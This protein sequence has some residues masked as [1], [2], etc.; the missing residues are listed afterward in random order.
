M[1]A[2]SVTGNLK[3]TAIGGGTDS[4][5]AKY[6]S[7][8]NQTW[9]RQVAP[10]SNDQANAVI[11]DASGNIYVGGQVN[12][13]IAVGQSSAGGTDA[14]VTK[15]TAQGALVY[16]RQLG[17]TADDATRQ[18]AIAADGNLVVA[19]VQN[20][21][22][23]LTKYGSADGTSAAL[24]QLDLGDLQGGG[25]SGLAIANGEIYLSGT[26]SNASLDASGAASVANPNSG[27]RD[28]FVFA[29]ADAGASVTADFVSYVGTG[30]SEQ[31]GGV[32]VAG[33]KLYLTGTTIGTF[34]GETPNTS[35]AHNLFVAE[36]NSDGTVNWTKQYGG[37][38][39]ESSGAAIVADESGASVLDALK[40]PRGTLRNNA[41]NQ[42]ESQTTVRAGDYF[43][44]K[45]AG[46]TGTREAKI[47][48]AEGE[49]LR[50]LAVKINGAL[51]FDG[52]ATALP[53]KGGQGLK[54]S[55]N[56]GVQVELVPG[57]KGFRCAR[58]I[59]FEAANADQ[60]SGPE[61]LRRQGH[62]EH[63]CERVNASDHRT[64]HRCEARSL[65]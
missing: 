29:A 56:A 2:G 25:L 5:V 6:D 19:S 51:L 55:V 7:D 34:P 53:I 31:G 42:I 63:R 43:T 12:G 18:V 45:I 14:Y 65:G 26:T 62:Q 40:L 49:T 61:E 46:K 17:T 47:T 64:W 10:A 13:P 11:I 58:G 37:L 33:G 39:G 21:H 15:L 22:A 35:S 48:I 1:V 50:S 52:K 32:A 28:A 27:G 16:Q 38:D 41:S 3:P 9:L 44:V 60:R 36:L 59:G 24:W 4:F 57:E 54:I 8:G 30:S 23:I 20:G